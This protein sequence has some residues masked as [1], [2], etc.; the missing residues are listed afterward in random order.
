MIQR[1]FITAGEVPEM[2]DDAV[3]NTRELAGYLYQM[4]NQ[5]QIELSNKDEKIAELKKALAA[6]SA[7]AG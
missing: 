5:L 3:R 6:Q 2:T 4:V 1:N 7:S